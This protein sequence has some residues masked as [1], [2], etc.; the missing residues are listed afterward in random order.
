MRMMKTF[1]SAHEFALYCPLVSELAHDSQADIYQLSDPELVQRI[2]TV[3]RLEKGD[4]II[5]FDSLLHVK[6]TIVGFDG[7]RSITIQLHDIEKN[8]RL[9]PEIQ[10]LLPLLKRE[11]FEEALYSLCE[12]GATSVQPVLTQKTTRFWAGEKEGLRAQRIMIAA[13]EQSK[14]FVMPFVHPIIPL[15]LCVIQSLQPAV[16]KLFFDPAG[17][18]LREAVAIIESQRIHH[19]IACTGPE[20][21]LTYEEKLLLTDQGFIFCALT[22][23]I[24]RAQEA[25]V[26]GL[27]ALRSL[28]S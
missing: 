24:L 15:E 26:V 12:L 2:V 13:A 19:I 17:I 6:A 11:A 4:T 18:P 14:Q 16:V 28:L 10:W 5:L 3:L 22:P 8:K 20:G 21:D 9:T 7:R 27:G 25:L 1:E 23:T